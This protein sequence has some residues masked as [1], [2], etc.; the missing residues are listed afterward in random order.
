MN[1]FTRL[2]TIS[3]SDIQAVRAR[4][5]E[6]RDTCDS[7]RLQTTE[8]FEFDKSDKLKF[9]KSPYATYAECIGEYKEIYSEGEDEQETN[10]CGLW[11]R[12]QVYYPA[13]APP[14]LVRRPLV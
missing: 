9:D 12:D 6:R 14:P 11:Q 7:Y 1:T 10:L 4:Y 13:Y 8:A 5:N 3:T 2:S